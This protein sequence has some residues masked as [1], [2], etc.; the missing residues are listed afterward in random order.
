MKQLCTGHFSGDYTAAR[1]AAAE[2]KDEMI[3]F[4]FHL[5]SFDFLKHD[6]FNFGIGLETISVS[7]IGLSDL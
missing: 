2:V 5:S 4:I 1:M 3:I 7:I 6:T